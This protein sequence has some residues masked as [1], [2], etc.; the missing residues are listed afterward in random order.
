MTTAEPRT[1]WFTWIGLFLAL[2]GPTF[3]AGPLA[4]IAGYPA[5]VRTAFVFLCLMWALLIPIGVIVVGPERQP[6]SSIGLRPFRW[7]SIGFGLAAAAAV[8]AA[9][10]A[11]SAF[12]S[13]TAQA[14]VARGVGTLAAWPLWLKILAV[15]TAG[16]VEETLYRGYA[17]TRLSQL[18]GSRIVAAGISLVAFTLAHLPYWGAGAAAV[19]LAGGLALTLLFL[20]KRDLL[21]VA[22]AHT[23]TDV[24]SLFVQ[25]ALGLAG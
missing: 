11:V 25:P 16:A 14:D 9:L 12:D 5:P 23:A 21:L 8:I 19:V 22:V 4:A 18:T 15:V 7:R 1:G 13:T 10:L 20:W 2:G 24:F 17:I 6:L 3:V